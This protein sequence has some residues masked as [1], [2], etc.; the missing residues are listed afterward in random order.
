MG[1]VFPALDK[2]RLQD[3]WM[4]DPSLDPQLHQQA[5]IGLRR[6][7]WISRTVPCMWQAVCNIMGSR[8]SARILDIACGGGDV[9]IGLAKIAQRHGYH[10]DIS[11]ADLSPTALH[12]AQQ[13]AAIQGIDLHTFTHDA[14]EGNWPGG[15]YDILIN[16]LMLHH[17]QEADVMTVL[18]NM[19]NTAQLGIVVS[20]LLRTR[21]GWLLT[22]CGVRLLTRC[23][24][25][26]VDGPRSVEGAFT[27]NELHSL[28]EQANLTGFTLKHAWPA[29]AML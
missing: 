22:H 8:R 27:Y 1:M 25:V 13:Y 23:P 26:H 20:D 15:P 29:R 24:V 18:A 6:I 12:F 3:E 19:Q 4:D 21:W 16:S 9:I 11:A 2:R 17:L 14:L 28:A 5:L 10:L 7:N